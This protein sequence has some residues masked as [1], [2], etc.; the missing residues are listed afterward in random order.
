MATQNND[1][2]A[3][4]QSCSS[5]FMRIYEQK[6]KKR[7]DFTFSKINTK[8]HANL[9]A[10]Q[11]IGHSVLRIGDVSHPIIRVDVV[12]AQHVKSV[13]AQP[14]ITEH[15]SNSAR[16]MPVFVVEQTVAH[17]D[18]HAFISRR[19]KCLLLTREDGSLMAWR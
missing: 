7:D 12:N 19:S 9:P 4:M 3:D 5:A 15:P 16:N 8:P 14:D 17:A 10:C 11:V 1:I 2:G 6:N 13:H 18:I